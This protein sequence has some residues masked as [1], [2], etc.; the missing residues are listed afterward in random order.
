MN[1]D[2]TSISR[3]TEIVMFFKDNIC[4]TQSYFFFYL[5]C[6][7][8]D[9]DQRYGFMIFGGDLDFS[10]CH[11]SGWIHNRRVPATLL[12]IAQQPAVQIYVMPD[13]AQ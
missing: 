12:K 9:L 13:F 10:K 1:L 7:R 2:P 5:K 3:I 4:F 6:S 11:G 8:L